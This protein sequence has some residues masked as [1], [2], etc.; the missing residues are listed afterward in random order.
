MMNRTTF[1]DYARRAP[2]CG[3]LTQSQIDGMTAILDEWDRRQS[4]DKV[5]QNRWLDYMLA[6]VFT[7]QAEPCSRT[8]VGDAD[9]GRYGL[10]R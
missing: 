8:A 10:R 4:T 9:R 3:R 7:R 1:L 6:T 2:F 5:V